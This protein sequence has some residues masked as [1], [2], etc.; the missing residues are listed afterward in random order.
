MGIPCTLISTFPILLNLIKTNPEQ[1][2]FSTRT[3]AIL[4]PF[5]SRQLGVNI[6][7]QFEG[8]HYEPGFIS[9]FKNI[10]CK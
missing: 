1:R 2:N 3:T 6:W 4:I 9:Q 7:C 8:V 10:F 5:L